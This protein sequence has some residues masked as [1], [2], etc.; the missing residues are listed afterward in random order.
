MASY[1]MKFL[2]QGDGIMK[3]QQRPLSWTSR[4]NN[5]KK[6]SSEKP[7]RYKSTASNPEEFHL[8][9]TASVRSNTCCNSDCSSIDDE[10]DA[11][12]PPQGT[13][14]S[15]STRRSMSTRQSML[16]LNDERMNSLRTL[17]EART[18][19]LLNCANEQAE[20]CRAIRRKA[21]SCL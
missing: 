11:P 15:S 5:N 10:K 1:A 19:A 21:P 8:E 7:H 2:H 9:R 3:P 16:L 20:V 12:P 17:N 13:T 4:R 18:K 14:C 6:S